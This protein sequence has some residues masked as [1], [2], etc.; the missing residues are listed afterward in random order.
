V[1]QTSYSE[2]KLQSLPS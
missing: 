2:G 1:F